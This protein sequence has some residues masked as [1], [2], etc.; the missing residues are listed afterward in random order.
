MLNG[1]HPEIVRPHSSHDR[2]LKYVYV[3]FKCWVKDIAKNANAIF[4]SLEVFNQN[5]KAF[6]FV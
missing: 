1:H 2:L 5:V 3:I 4:K 6:K